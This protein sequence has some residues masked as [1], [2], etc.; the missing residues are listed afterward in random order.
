VSLV[1]KYAWNNGVSPYSLGASFFEQS[2][3]ADPTST[4]E[5][6]ADANAIRAIGRVGRR[7]A[8]RMVFN[9]P[10]QC[11]FLMRG[12]CR[13]HLQVGEDEPILNQAMQYAVGIM[14][15]V[16]DDL[17]K[18]VQGIND[19]NTEIGGMMATVIQEVD[20]RVDVVME[21]MA[22]HEDRIKH[23]ETDHP[24]LVDRL[25]DVTDHMDV[26]ED[27]V[28]DHH[29]RLIQLDV[30]NQA[31][32]GQVRVL[33]ERMEVVEERSRQL[34]LFRAAL[35]HGPANPVVVEDDVEELWAGDEVAG[36]E[37]VPIPG[38][39]VPI[40]DDV[41]DEYI[42]AEEA[43]RRDPVPSYKEALNQ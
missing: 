9:H 13:H 20:D 25:S 2:N 30:E 42:P 3:T 36:G 12:L 6:L 31:L 39:L 10:Y 8:K 21:D 41:G 38:M 7:K 17:C 23:L 16:A 37:H 4:F 34:L 28:V 27:K 22:D 19:I 11:S 24:V 33:F 40:E 35:Q 5:D 32:R 18:V 43:A 1:V 15:M 14:A 29:D 26:V